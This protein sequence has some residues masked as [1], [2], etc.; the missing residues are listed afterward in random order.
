MIKKSSIWIMILGLIFTLLPPFGMEVMADSTVSKT[1][2]V[3]T[4]GDDVTG[5]GTKE[6]P[7]KTIAKA[8]EVV[9]T[10]PKDDGD[11]VVQIADGFYPIDEPLVFTSEDSGSE[12]STIRYEAAP[13]AK[14]VISAGEMLEKGVWTEATELTQTGGL[15]AY[16]TTLHRDS[17][18]RAIYV[19]DRRANMTLSPKITEEHRTVSGTPVVSFTSEGNPWAWQDG[20]NIPAAIVFD[21]SVGLTTETKN[22]QNI[23]AESMDGWTARWARPFITFASVEEAP[24]AS[25]MPGG[26]MFRFQMPYG[27]ISQSLSNN[28]HY[29]PNNNQVIRNAFEF[30]NKRGDF[31]FDQAE[32]TLYYI[33]LEGED[34]NTADVVIPR[35]E[36]IIDI[37]GIPVGDRL[38]PIEGS[39]DGRVKYITFDGLTFAHTDYKLYELTGTVTYSDGSGPVTTTSYGYASVQGSM[40]NTAY[41]PSSELNWHETFYRSYDIPPAAIMINAARHIKVLN[42]EVKLTGFNG[43]HIEND[44]K[45]IEITGNYIAETLASAIIIGHPTHIY[46]NDQPIV[47]ESRADYKGQPIRDWAGIDKEKFVAGTEAVPEDIYITNNFMYRNCYGFPGGN[48]LQSFYT[49]NMQVLHNFVYDTTY[50]AMS[51]GWG[52]DEFDGYGFTSHG[53]NKQ[54]GPYHGTHENSLARSPEPSTTSRNNKINYNRIEEIATVVNDTG[55]I[56]SLGRQGDPGN[57]PGG[58]TWDTVNDLTSNPVV[59]KN[60]NWHPDNWTNYTEMNYNFLNPNPTGKPTDPNNWTN[61][62]HPD[63]G[64]TFIKMIGNVVQSKLSH[65]PGQSRLFEFNNWKRKSDMIAIEGYVDGDNH[66]NGAPRIVYD[67]YKSEDRI[68]PLRGN[69]IVLNSGLENEYT[70]MIPRSIIADTEFELAS[71]VIMGKNETLKRRGLLK[72]EDTVWLAP[73]NTTEFAEGPTMTKAAGDEQSIQSPS[74]PGEYKLYIVYDDGRATATSK[75]TVYVDL[76]MSSINVEDGQTYD[77]SEVRPL[78]LSL[79]EDNTYTLNGEPVE[80]GYKISTEG[81][82]TLVISTPTEPNSRTIQF[83]TTV[84]L[85]NKLLPANVQV[86]PGGEVRFAYDLDDETKSI[87]ISSSSGGHFDGGEDETVVSGDKISMK[88]PELPGPYVIFVLAENGEVLSQSHANVVVRDMTPVDIPRDGLD[89]WLKADEGVERDS[90]GNVTGWTNMGNIEAK[91]VPADVPGSGG[92]GLGTPSGNPK[93]KN[94]GYDYVEFDANA[95]PLKAAGFKDYNGKEEMTIYTLVRPTTTVNNSSDQNGLVYFGMNEP[96]QGWAGNDGWSGISLGVGTNGVNVR[97]GNADG[98]VG[99]GGQH[100][101]TTATDGLVSVRA[102]L[103]GSNRAVFVNNQLIGSGT[104]A[105]ALH[106]NRSDLAVGYTMASATPYRFMGEVLQILIYDRVLSAGEVAKIEAYFNEVRAG[107]GGIAN[108]IDGEAVDTTLLNA[109][110]DSVSDKD[111]TQYTRESW[112]VFES[113]LLAA[114]AAASDDEIGQAEA[115]QAYY[116]LRDAIKGL[117]LADEQ[118][119]VEVLNEDFNSYDAGTGTLDEFI[120]KGQN[121]QVSV[122]ANK[123]LKFAPT[124]GGNIRAQTVDEF[125]DME[126][127]FDFNVESAEWDEGF[128]IYLRTTDRTVPA[129]ISNRNAIEL[130]INPGFWEK[131]RLFDHVNNATQYQRTAAVDI[132]TNSWYTSKFVLEGNM[133]YAKFW[134]RGSEEPAEWSMSGAMSDGAVQRGKGHI[135]F[136][137]FGNGR[138]GLID[139]V[140]VKELRRPDESAAIGGVASA[141]AGQSIALPLGVKHLADGFDSFTAVVQYDPEVLEFETVVDEAHGTV[142][143]AESAVT[144]VRNHWEVV[145]TEVKE[146]TGEIFIHAATADGSLDL[147]SGKLLDLNGKIAALTSANTTNVSVSEFILAADGVTRQ[148]ATDDAIHVIQV[149]AAPVIPVTGISLNETELRLKEGEQAQLTATITPVDATNQAVT[150]SSSDDGVATVDA[151][152]IVTAVQA[153]TATITATTVDGSY[154]ASTTVTV[155]ASDPTK[156]SEVTNVEVIP[157]DQQLTLTWND[158]AN[159]VKVKLVVNSKTVTDDVYVVDQGVEYFV[160]TN[161]TNGTEYQIKISTIDADDNESD[162][163]TV[164]GTP[165][166]LS[167]GIDTTPPGEVTNARVYSGDGQLTIRWTDPIDDDLDSIKISGYGLTV[168]D[169]VYV[170][171]GVETYTFTGL[172]NNTLYEFIITTL[173]ILENESAGVIVYGTP[174]RPSSSGPSSPSRRTSDRSDHTSDDPSD[175]V[176]VDVDRNGEVH[177][178]PALDANGAAKVTL[179]SETI[180]RALEQAAGDHLQIRVEADGSMNELHVEL[181]VNDIFRNDQA[182]IDR[183]ELDTGLAKV[184]VSTELIA[185]A[186]AAPKQVSISVA[187]ADISGLTGEALEKLK[188]AKVYDLSLAIDGEEVSELDGRSDVRVAIPYE[189]QPGEDPN[190]VVAY[191]IDDLGELKVV[192]NGRYN[193]ETGMVEFR[194]KQPGTFAASHV[195]VSFDDV[196][197]GWA[198][199]AIDALAARGIVNGIG[200]R[201]FDPDSHVTR[202]EFITMLM[203]LFELTNEETSTTLSDVETGAWYYTEI[204]TAQQLG[205]VKGK[206][207]GSFGVNDEISRQDMA[208]MAYRALQI[209]QLELAEGTTDRFADYAR[210]AE[211]AQDAV[212]AMQAAGIIHGMGN[213]EFAPD[214]HAT[215]AQAAMIIYN[216]L[217]QL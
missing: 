17:K 96:Y 7:Y 61:G 5:D 45:D 143:L 86:A 74:E 90:S 39:D 48:A 6:N 10:L 126:L 160:L 95:R 2:Y 36:T 191:Y 85:A 59:D 132:Q 196:S 144:N 57:L 110:I 142:R 182:S 158:P 29:N 54:G 43:I 55:A 13:G 216:L 79:S 34:I 40:V 200:G 169:A 24:A 184:T 181:P 113:A 14:P 83:R 167:G 130:G 145:S 107:E 173:D 22:P 217:N 175:G 174:R 163:I 52:W 129:N 192:K 156:P 44:V 9:R 62:F 137:F 119:Y 151:N 165:T 212:A 201:L 171:K 188:D 71:N 177:V 189:L 204:A 38:D 205:I 12:N 98:S 206:P 8:K 178:Q 135:S 214:A 101:S 139:N 170:N 179:D 157:G 37:R 180:E 65:A 125:G 104:N 208:V 56:Y 147:D 77:V 102:Q 148:I 194:P 128:Y 4:D 58:G 75:Y 199:D 16:K 131:L 149:I 164:F 26:V 21:A 117:Q 155:E 153:G 187:V 93:I 78:V 53:T 111:F 47:H 72:P 133:L 108:P 51:I 138:S 209:V 122:T 11:I 210:V 103:D 161:L 99:G 162:G 211:Y 140:V 118:Q 15:T 197:E 92:D 185:K 207:D 114:K 1:I 193:E 134:P 50:G 183:I 159:I 20:N 97:F 91:L 88:A 146:D 87:W 100:F 168:T 154:T 18:L 70:H 166:S 76:S 112:S 67:N 82:W 19:N 141:G 27:A 195:S 127:T 64:S 136:E 28:T 121:N 120:W 81:S 198:K 186:S 66:M 42:G 123:E 31:Y 150:W 68:W 49:T 35:H 109:L 115:D 190:Q 124:E 30:L 63:E 172:S 69:E 106:G 89:L 32:S 73:P 213:G 116:A 80:S 84:S 33:P 202:A 46:E 23:E 94:D 25:G 176:K 105:K 203:N 215:R 152:G 3:A 60:H 41:F